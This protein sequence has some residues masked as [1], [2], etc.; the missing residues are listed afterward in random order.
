MV[1]TTNTY[2]FD[3]NSPAELGRLINQDQMQTRA[4][5]G[6]FAG[7][8]NEEVAGFRNVLDLA[9]GPGGWVL[10]AAF[11][12]PAIEV[13]GIDISRPMID[14]ASARASSQGVTNATFGVMDVTQPLDFADG[15][16]DLVNARYL[17]GV[18]KR[19]A[20]MFLLTESMRLLRPGG[21]LRLT[22]PVVYPMTTS[23]AGEVINR[24][25]HQALWYR[26]YGFSSDGETSGD[27]VSFMLPR[28]LRQAG[29]QVVKYTPH[30]LEISD[31]TDAWA[32][33]YRNMEVGCLMAKPLLINTGVVLSEEFDRLYRQM[34]IEW[35]TPGF[36][37]LW[38]F[39]TA[40]GYK[41]A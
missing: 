28:L 41:P 37:G 11:P 33:F 40:W 29:Y 15:T 16:F 20:W 17:V 39:L 22:E 24:L 18:L 10:D 23:P 12:H 8:R 14:Y 38:H 13:A 2:M 31:D 32:N 27:A 25:L 36:T 9:C 21:I 19:E 7:L 3:P 35:N 4:M 6:P 26:G 34:L 1:D 30:T 5:G